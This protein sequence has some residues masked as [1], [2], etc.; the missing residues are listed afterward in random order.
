MG[1]TGSGGR[2]FGQQKLKKR[3][4]VQK[5][6][7]A[8][9]RARN[10]PKER[11]FAVDLNRTTFGKLKVDPKKAKRPLVGKQIAKD[12]YPKLAGTRIQLGKGGLPVRVVSEDGKEFQPQKLAS[13]RRHLARLAQL[14]AEH[15]EIA[16]I[17][18]DEVPGAEAT[19]KAKAAA[20]DEIAATAAP[21]K[22]PRIAAAV[23]ADGHSMAAPRRPQLEGRFSGTV[24]ERNKK[25]VWVKLSPGQDL[26]IPAMV[27]LEDAQARRRA[28]VEAG[29][30]KGAPPEGALPV[31]LIQ[32]ADK[33]LSLT[34]GTL[35]SFKLQEEQH[36]VSGSHI[37]LGKGSTS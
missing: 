12:Q 31:K 8:A 20:A 2:P 28:A 5:D 16:R 30:A 26:P 36:G 13:A 29:H 21:A 7:H 3:S 1:K 6:A 10:A 35:V 11:T 22:R 25:V 34:I 15:D 17:R 23:A 9:P 18:G 19:G 32:K 33:A 24:L 27:K 14:K 37:A 4:K